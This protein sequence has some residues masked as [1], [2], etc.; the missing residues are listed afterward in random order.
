M[1]RWDVEFEFTMHQTVVVEAETKKEALEK[2]KLG[3]YGTAEADSWAVPDT[4]RKFKAM[5][6]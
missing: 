5:E 2:V 3:N 4:R 6:Q 1:A